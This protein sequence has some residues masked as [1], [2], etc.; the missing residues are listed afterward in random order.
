MGPRICIGKKF[1]EN[2]IILTL[3]KAVLNFK[4]SSNNE[5]I[6]PKVEFTLKPEKH[7]KVIIEKR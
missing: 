5:I 4:F 2:E 6:Q 1:A 3:A 7:I